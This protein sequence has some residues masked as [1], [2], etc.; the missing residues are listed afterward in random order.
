MLREELVSEYDCEFPQYQDIVSFETYYT[1]AQQ[2]I[3]GSQKDVWKHYFD[4]YKDIP[5]IKIGYKIGFTTNEREVN[6]IIINPGDVESFFEYI[7]VYLYDDIHQTG[8]WYSHV[9]KEEF[10]DETVFT[11]IKLTGSTKVDDIISPVT[12]VV[13]AYQPDGKMEPDENNSYQIVVKRK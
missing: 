7:Q 8:S 5:N 9:T 12:L 11:S 2:L 13:F 3:S 1:S 4:T 6:Q 10:N